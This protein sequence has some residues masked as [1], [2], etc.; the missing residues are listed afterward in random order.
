MAEAGVGSAPARPS[1][2]ELC[3]SWRTAATANGGLSIGVSEQFRLHANGVRFHELSYNELREAA[4][5]LTEGLLLPGLNTVIDLDHMLFWSWCGELLLG[6][7]GPLSAGVDPQIRQLA[8][9]AV[10]TALANARPYTEEAFERARQASD[11]LEH[12]ANQYLMHAHTVLPYLA[13]PLLE[14]VS[15]R[16]CANY[17]DLTGRVLAPFPRANGTAYAV[18]TRC[19]NVSDLLRLLVS[20]IAAPSLQS[21]L[22]DL[23]AHIGGLQPGGTTDGYAVLF[24]W[25]N[26]SLHGETSLSTIGGTVLTV[27]LLIALDALRS[28][29]ETYRGAALSRAQREVNSAQ[30]LGRWRPSPWSYYPPFP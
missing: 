10:R 9:S 22:L 5:G 15:R 28:D 2:R 16:A 27:A 18:G 21:D 14:A 13:F 12:N 26:S 29:Y 6:Q 30:S 24:D 8:E 23:L 20:N 11:L 19:S 4:V 7:G 3:R 1:I 25:R 17:V